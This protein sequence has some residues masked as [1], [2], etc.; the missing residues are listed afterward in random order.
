VKIL[1]DTC[2]ISDLVSKKPSLDVVNW[3]DAQDDDDICL[4]I[5]TIGEIV[6]GIERLPKSK[7][8]QELY[9]WL[10]ND[11]LARF[12]GKILQID[13]EVI[14]EWGSLTAKMELAGRPM[15]AI[16]SLIAAIALVNRCALATRNVRDFE[17]SGV[18]TINPWDR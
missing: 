5:I 13:L 3:L 9:D 1:L 2:V 12:Q 16:D 8:K 11:L 18:E 6:K 7:R 4:S 17:G 10:R 14:V 15:P